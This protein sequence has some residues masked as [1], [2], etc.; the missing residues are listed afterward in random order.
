[1]AFV[2]SGAERL[3]LVFTNVCRKF[4]LD[5]T[6]SFPDS[7]FKI[8]YSVRIF[9]WYIFTQKYYLV[10]RNI[11]K[12]PVAAILLFFKRSNKSFSFVNCFDEERFLALNRLNSD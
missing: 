1:M 11:C 6:N 9:L 3:K 7:G 12:P 10:Y 5:N 8:Q 2:A 4:Y